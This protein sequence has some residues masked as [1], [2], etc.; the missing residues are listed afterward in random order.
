MTDLKSLSLGR[1]IQTLRKEQGLTQ[2]ALAER[3]GVTPQAVSKWEN[4]LSCPDIMSLP[5]LARELHITVDTLLTGEYIESAPATPVKP[6]EE[7]IVRIAIQPE[8]DARVC[9]NLPFP[10]F[11]LGVLHDLFSFT[12][13]AK[14]GELDAEELAQQLAQVDFRAIVLLIEQGARG[15]LVNAGDMLA[16]WV[17]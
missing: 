8:N 2:D 12:F 4:D 13:S 5:M 16:I 6:A 14:E 7:L 17:E 11:R 1:R 3:M 10:V 9:L 15:T